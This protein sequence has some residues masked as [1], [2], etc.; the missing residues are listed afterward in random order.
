[1][2]LSSRKGSILP[3]AK[4]HMRRYVPLASFLLLCQVGFL[5]EVSNLFK[6]KCKH[7]THMQAILCRHVQLLWNYCGA[8]TEELCT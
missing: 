2:H 5:A 4:N 8:F 3:C 7:M 6:S 1:M